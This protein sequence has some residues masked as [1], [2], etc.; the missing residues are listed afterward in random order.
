MSRYAIVKSSFAR[1]A[2]RFY[3]RH[4]AACAFLLALG[5]SH[6]AGAHQA[7]ITHS[8]VEIG[9]DQTELTY[10]IKFEPP[11][12]S[13]VL[14]LGEDVDPTDQAV[15]AGQDRLLDFVLQRIDVRDGDRKCPVERLGAQVVRQGERFVEVA[16][17]VRCAKAFETLVIE[18]DLFF[19]LDP[20]HRGLVQ[21]RYRDQRAV[22]ELKS[23]AARFVWELDQP[24]PG[25]RVAFIISG[26]EHIVFGF[27]HIAFLLGLLLVVAIAR[28]PQPSPGWQRRGLGGGLR[29]TAAIVTSFTVAHSITLIAASLDWI[30]LDSRLVESVIAASIVYVAVEDIIKPD[31]RYRF[32]LTFGFGLVHGLGFASMLKVLLPPEDVIWPLLMFN[33]GVELGQLAIVLAVLPA[34]HVLTRAVGADAYRTRFLPIGAGVLAV[35]G[36]LW[37]VERVF[38]VTLLGF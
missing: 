24:P 23:D 2:R 13:E 35:L 21:V 33:V 36:T 25:N 22:A 31:T 15:S 18:Y 4:A 1:L 17:R 38:D 34:L 8:T 32:L 10:R 5:A 19:D 20:L 9:H 37:L 7:S 28:A 12:L 29:Y 3:P 11:D 27:D 26:V 16:F 14:G 30:S 6:V